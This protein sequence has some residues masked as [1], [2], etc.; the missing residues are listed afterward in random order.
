ML[1][2]LYYTLEM[3]FAMFFSLDVV[4]ISCLH[5]LDL[6]LFITKQGQL[7]SRFM[8]NEVMHL[9]FHPMQ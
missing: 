1:H 8:H 7:F 9:F 2:I 4:L 3:K 6:N 5:L